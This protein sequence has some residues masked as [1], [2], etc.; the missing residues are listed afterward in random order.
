[1]QN[2]RVNMHIHVQQPLVNALYSSAHWP[3]AHQEWLA[4]VASADIT[5]QSPTHTPSP[6][7]Q[8]TQHISENHTP[9]SIANR[10]PKPR[11]TKSSTVNSRKDI[12]TGP[13][14]TKKESKYFENAEKCQV[15][16]TGNRG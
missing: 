3:V 5:K 11:R 15:H 16:E 8:S 12:S 7:P 2:V 6:T 1:M 9:S 4:E 14:I 13:T 10:E